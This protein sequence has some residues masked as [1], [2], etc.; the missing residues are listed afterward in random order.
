MINHDHRRHT[1]AE[2]RT[3]TS[4]VRGRH[5]EVNALRTRLNCKARLT[6]LGWARAIRNVD[7]IHE[8]LVALQDRLCN[9]CA[10]VQEVE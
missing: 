3:L 9:A 8:P 2:I 4:E 6:P 7:V 5:A 10:A 1:W